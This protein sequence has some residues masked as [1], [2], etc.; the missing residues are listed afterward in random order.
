MKTINPGV[1]HLRDQG[2][3]SL[4]ISKERIKKHHDSQLGGLVDGI[5]YDVE[6]DKSTAYFAGKGGRYNFELLAD[7]SKGK[8]KQTFE[9]LQGAVD[10][11]MDAS[12]SYIG[13]VIDI[14][15]FGIMVGRSAYEYDYF[16]ETGSPPNYWARDNDWEIDFSV[17]K[18]GSA[19]K[20]GNIAVGAF[21][22][23]QSSDGVV[24]F[25]YYDPD[26]GLKGSTED[27]DIDT[28]TK[29]FGLG[30]GYSTKTTHI[31]ISQEQITSQKLT[32]AND[33]PWDIEEAELSN[34]L[35]FVAERKFSWFAIG[36]RY[37][38]INGNFYDLEDVISA[39]LLYEDIGSSDTRTDTTFNISFGSKGL[40]YSAF[41]SSAKT[42]FEEPNPYNDNGFLYPATVESQ[43]YGVNL[44]FIY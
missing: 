9:D 40:S 3:L 23:S 31:E 11:T 19:F 33:F 42:E 18:I 16:L 17:I 27:Y 39:K 15:W 32:K 26:T 34:R 35:S 37:R 20:L 30:V 10:T 13:G 44:S 41:Y 22:L 1:S 2:F 14:K 43:A 24:D 25:T 38:Q 7:Q 5:H 8:L 29:G 12:A 21:Y 4:D 28:E 6:V 36:L